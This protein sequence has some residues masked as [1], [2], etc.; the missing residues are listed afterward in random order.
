MTVF[1]NTLFTGLPKKYIRELQ[2][3]QKAAARNLTKTKK[4][5][6]ITPIL[7][8]LH[9]LTLSF[10]I[11]FKVLFLVYQAL[12]ALAPC[13]NQDCLSFMCQ[14]EHSDR[15]LQAHSRYLWLNINT[16]VRVP[17]VFTHQNSG[18]PSQKYYNYGLGWQ[19]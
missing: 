2:I 1:C 4:R 18:T 3:I 12:N 5:E 10:R 6:H 7:A 13:Y 11:H 14:L 15:P 16:V 19:F 8:A 9:W 17:S